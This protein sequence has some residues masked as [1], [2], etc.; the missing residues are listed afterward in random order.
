MWRQVAFVFGC[1][2]LCLLSPENAGAQ[3][4]TEGGKEPPPFKMFR[5]EEDYSYLKPGND[6]IY[7]SSFGEELK[8]IA[9]NPQGTLYA[10]VGGQYRV[11]WEHFTHKSWTDDTD[12]YYSQR[13][14]IHLGIHFG[15]A[16]R[17]FGELYHGLTTGDRRVTQDEEIDL[18]QGFIEWSPDLGD[19]IQTISARLGRQELSLGISRLVGIREGPNIRRSFDLARVSYRRGTY[20]GRCTL[21]T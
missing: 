11:R 13:L 12:Q 19:G 7:T 1:V 21:W 17:V 16:I 6:P 4:Q 8:Y 10:T 9:I 15:S 2:L 5:A 3:E 20:C 18:H 14:N